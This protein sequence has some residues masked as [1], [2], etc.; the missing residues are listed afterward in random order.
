[1]LAV[2][3]ISVFE[4]HVSINQVKENGLDCDHTAQTILAGSDL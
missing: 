2:A 1:M 3:A 4:A